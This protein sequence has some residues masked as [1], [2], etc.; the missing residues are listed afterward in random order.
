M[1]VYEALKKRRSIR[2]YTGDSVPQEAIDKIIKAGLLAPSSR[3]IWPCDFVL[4]KD[5]ET[6]A[7]LSAI[8]SHGA[9]MLKNADAAIC[10]VADH[11]RSDVCIE[12]S[13]VAM[14]AMMLEATELGIGNCWV[15][16]R[17]RGVA[18]PD[19]KSKVYGPISST[20]DDNARKIL[21]YPES[22]ELLAILSLGMPAAWPDP[23]S[24]DDLDMD[25]VHLEKY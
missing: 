24:E 9:G 4:V 17:L 22:C 18:A 11:E 1:D 8:K 19:A 15:Q 6:L 23:R 16:C 7:A 20:A 5:K 12:D 25:K 13:S 3:G 14:T 2:K 21:G 10:I